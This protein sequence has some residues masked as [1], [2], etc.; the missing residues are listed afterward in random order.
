VAGDW[1][2]GIGGAANGSDGSSGMAAVAG[3]FG[4]YLAPDRGLQLR[5]RSLYVD[6]G[7]DR[8]VATLELGFEFGIPLALGDGGWRPFVGPTVGLAFGESINESPTL[9]VIAGL[10]YFVQPRAALST[11][12]HYNHLMTT[13]EDQT[14][15]YSDTLVGWSLGVSLL[16]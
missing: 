8:S 5:H 6:H 15:I 3:S 7:Q 10:R 9:G 11:S 16:F 12:F 2:L 14:E 4:Y 13:T 1:E